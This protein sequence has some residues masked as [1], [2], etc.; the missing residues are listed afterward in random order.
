MSSSLPSALKGSVGLISRAASGSGSRPSSLLSSGLG[1]SFCDGSTSFSGRARS[2]AGGRSFS[3]GTSFL[4]IFS[5]VAAAGS[6]RDGFASSAMLFSEASGFVGLARAEMRLQR[7]ELPVASSGTFAA[8]TASASELFFSVLEPS[9]SLKR[10]RDDFFFF[11]AA[12]SCSDARLPSESCRFTLAKLFA[13][14]KDTDRF[15]WSRHML[16]FSSAF[17]IMS[18][19]STSRPSA[20]GSSSSSASFSDQSNESDGAVRTSR[21]FR[22]S[23]P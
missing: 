12:F 6:W 3:H 15:R 8:G 19:T 16:R 4:S 1:S 2:F 5:D 13:W 18:G 20:N 14:L 17:E 11:R 7:S 9:F 22:R 10:A 23:T 21:I